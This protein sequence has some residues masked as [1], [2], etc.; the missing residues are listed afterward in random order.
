[1]SYCVVGNPS[2]RNAA[3][4]RWMTVGD[5]DA[6]GVDG[7]LVGEIAEDAGVADD[8]A[9]HLAQPRRVE[10]PPASVD[11]VLGQAEDLAELA[12]HRPVLEGVVGAEQGDVLVA[13]EDVACDVVAVRPREVEV[14]VGRIGPVEVDE[15][16]EV[17][18]QFNRVDV[19]DAEEVGDEA[20]GLAA[21]GR[22][23]SSPW[24]ARRR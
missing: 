5:Q 17:E 8:G 1:M 7:N 2:A 14:E 12:H 6:A 16:L 3:Q 21:P 4:V 15:P 23:G 19:G 18:V 20:V 11:L 9:L 24:T 13:V 10:P 22:R